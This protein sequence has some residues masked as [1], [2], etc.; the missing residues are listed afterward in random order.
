[1]EC[2]A[3]THVFNDIVCRICMFVCRDCRGSLRPRDVL[4][5][6]KQSVCASGIVGRELSLAHHLLCRPLTR[7]D[8][9]ANWLCRGSDMRLGPGCCWS[10]RLCVP[11]GS[12]GH[13][14]YSSLS[15]TLDTPTLLPHTGHAH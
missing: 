13:V 9:P 14:S 2:Q 7:P 10:G 11:T 15:C 6:R 8:C 4:V 3:V 5:R 12:S 1:M